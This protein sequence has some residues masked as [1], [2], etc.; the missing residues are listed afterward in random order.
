MTKSITSI[1]ILTLAACGLAAPITVDLE[2]VPIESESA[3]F[4]P[5]A[6]RGATFS[7]YNDFTWGPYWEGFSCSSKNDVT[8]PG[9][10]SQFAAYSNLGGS[11][12]GGGAGGMGN[13]AVGFIGFVGATPE[14]T[15]PEVQVVQSA[16]FTNVTYTALSM[17]DGDAFSKK[18][19]GDD[20]SEEDWYK[21]TI[22]GKDAAG[23]DTGEVEFYLADYRFTDSG[24]DYVLDD[25]TQV[26]LSGLGP[27]KSLVFGLSSTDNGVFGMNTP[28]YFTMD[29][30]VYVPE[31]V[32]M[33][34][35]AVGAVAA[36]GR[37]QIA[38]P[39]R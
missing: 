16:L 25:W 15:F 26:D 23:D 20:G 6:S 13:Y 22:T 14:V 3:W 5:F 36:L 24:Q 4:G 9:L 1:T 39:R 21:L 32:T 8:T 19:G 17:L 7:N 33:V 29:N 30:L 37:R 10:P 18:F 38:R 34:V 28:A 27:V 35:L 12:A 2:D 31:P 11:P